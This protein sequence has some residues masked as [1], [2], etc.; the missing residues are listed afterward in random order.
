MTTTLEHAEAT[1]EGL[2]TKLDEARASLADIDERRRN[3]AYKAHVEGG[4]AKR[5]LDKLNASYTAQLATLES[6]EAAILEASRRVA[7]A[8]RD[9]ALEETSR[10]AEE[11]MTIASE[12]LALGQKIDDAL[13]ALAE[14]ANEY[15]AHIKT[16]NFQLNITHPSGMQLQSAFTRVLRAKIAFINSMKSAVEFPAPSERRTASE[17]ASGHAEA[18]ARV[19]GPRIVV[20][21]AAE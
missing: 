1:R 13:A 16:L 8:E 6:L 19:A 14:A 4:E 10:Q 20:K 9:V 17:V 7:D 3:L 2:R 18:I 11:A 12:L 5:E 21:E 15:E